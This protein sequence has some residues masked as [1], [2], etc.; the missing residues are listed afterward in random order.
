VTPQKT[1]AASVFTGMGGV[2]YHPFSD[3]A[4][5]HM[6]SGLAD[7]INQGAARIAKKEASYSNYGT[8]SIWS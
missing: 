4:L 8:V 2:T 6:G 7:G 5:H 3:F 1:S